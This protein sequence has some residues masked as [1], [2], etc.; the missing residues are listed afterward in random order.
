[1]SLASISSAA[2]VTITAVL[3]GVS[4]CA[5]PPAETPP[6][7]GGTV[8]TTGGT[9]TTTTPPPTGGGTATVPVYYLGTVR[10]RVVLYREFHSVTFVDGIAGRIGAAVAEMMRN[11]PLDPDYS[12]AWPAGATVRGVRIE[13]GVAVVDL[14]GVANNSVGAENAAMTIQQLVWTVTAVAADAGS[15]V[16]GVRL[17]ID[18]STRSELWG[19]VSIGGVLRRGASTNT[20]A[21]V[22]LIAPQHGDTVGRS[23]RVH[24]DGTVFEATAVVRVRNASGAVVDERTVTLSTG[25]PGRGEAFLELN[26]APGRYTLEAFYYSP[27][28]SSIQAMDDHEITVA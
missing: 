28:D 5:P 21:Q 4:S 14:A 20:Q 16:D 26:L 7:P 12:S 3:V 6:P 13:A 17:L 27:A 23:V 15:P 25:A 8:S 19:H 24:I 18:G 9:A 10:D 2:V 1:M 11:D 22:W